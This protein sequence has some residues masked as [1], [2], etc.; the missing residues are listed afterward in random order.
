MRN[1]VWLLRRLLPF[2]Y[3]V[4]TTWILS[5]AIILL[6]SASV[7]V[8]VECI[9]N[10][11]IADRVPSTPIDN[12]VLEWL[13]SIAA[14]VLSNNTPYGSLK[15]GAVFLGVTIFFVAVCRY[16]KSIIFA[17][18]NENVLSTIRS[19]LFNHISLLDLHFTRTM[20]SGKTVSLLIQDV[21]NLGYAIIDSLDRLFLQPLR[22]LFFTYLLYSLSPVL[23]VS[24]YLIVSTS[25]VLTN[26]F[27]AFIE[28]KTKVLME[29]TAELHGKATE[30]LSV[31]ILS[32]IFNRE[33][34]EQKRWQYRCDELARAR[35]KYSLV[36]GL[37]PLMTNGYKVVT[38]GSIIVIGGYFV[39]VRNSLSNEALAKIVLLIPVLLYSMEALATL[40]SSIRTSNASITRIWDVL[41]IETALPKNSGEKD[42]EIPKP[43]FPVS[44]RNIKKVFDQRAVLDNASFTID[45]KQTVLLYGKSGS[46]KSTLLT[47]VAGLA[48]AEEG[49]VYVGEQQLTNQNAKSWR[50]RLGIVLQE[51]LFFNTS[52]RKNL[53]Y[54]DSGL[55]DDELLEAIHEVFGDEPLFQDSSCLDRIMG[56]NGNNFSGGERQRLSIV[57][58][59]LKNPDLLILDEPTSDLDQKN[60]DIV[61]TTLKKL[62]GRVTMVIATHDAGL[63]SL[64]DKVYRVQNAT[65]SPEGESEKN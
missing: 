55:G 51:S 30:Y 6:Q 59:L 38:I 48:M 15:A 52:V 11:L 44:G 47:L 19:E 2:K 29:T 61:I 64:A 25:F 8:S 37:F 1:Y 23:T 45:E 28:K 31:A 60:R 39:F 36:R 3:L 46:G 22:V 41:D 4:I 12:L 16:I 27:G 58:A 40:Y 24:I 17:H 14:S 50:A 43:V 63:R 5:V 13:D 65:L 62:T 33:E 10:I 57:R 49:G 18:I 21:D 20:K 7:W 42:E 53:L 56:N 26:I 54:T 35:V 34:H 32:R 9:Q